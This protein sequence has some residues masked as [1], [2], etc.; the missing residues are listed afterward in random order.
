LPLLDAVVPLAVHTVVLPLHGADHWSALVMY[1]SE[2]S[3]QRVVLHHYDSFV[4]TALANSLTLH[5]AWAH[6]AVAGWNAPT[7]DLFFR[8]SSSSRSLPGVVDIVHERRFPIQGDAHSCGHRVL[9]LIDLLAE[10]ARQ[11]LYGV[12]LSDAEMSQHFV[13]SVF[14]ERMHRLLGTLHRHLGAFFP[15]FDPRDRFEKQQAY[16]KLD[17]ALLEP[18]LADGERLQRV[19]R[20]TLGV[21]AD[22]LEA[23]LESQRSWLCP[24]LALTRDYDTCV[25]RASVFGLVPHDE[26]VATVVRTTQSARERAL[27][28]ERFIGI[29]REHLKRRHNELLLLAL[30]LATPLTP[31]VLPV[32]TAWQC[33][34]VATMVLATLREWAYGVWH[35][36]FFAWP[37]NSNEQQYNIGVRQS[38]LNTLV[39]YT[40]DTTRLTSALGRL[41]VHWHQHYRQRNVLLPFAELLRQVCCSLVCDECIY[42]APIRVR[43]STSVF[44]PYRLADDPVPQH[45]DRLLGWA[46]V[47]RAAAAT[48]PPL[49]S[50]EFSHSPAPRS[51]HLQATLWHAS[52][53]PL[54][55]TVMHRLCRGEQGSCFSHFVLHHAPDPQLL[56]TQYAYAALCHYY[57]DVGN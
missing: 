27:R 35:E 15:G 24:Q 39:H 8:S 31:P 30:P 17:P 48:G 22:A 13:S 45:H 41:L 57:E 40:V 29:Y 44:G 1:R 38:L 21:P 10:R 49:L 55:E 20:A 6:E 14:G 2:S 51:Y 32:L 25:D 37:S 3:H 19:Y 43:A 28:A 33:C 23:L 56:F 18:A 16:R 5:E 12:P 42:V 9:T 34:S 53:R 36:M 54:S 4:N 11:G 52:V 50:L 26:F 7:R 47:W 46:A